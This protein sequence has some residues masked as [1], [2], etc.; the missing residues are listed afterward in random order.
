MNGTNISRIEDGTASPVWLRRC[1]VLIWLASVLFSARP[2]AQTPQLPDEEWLFSDWEQKTTEVNEGT[3]RVLSTPPSTALHR[4]LNRIRI[5]P[6]SLRHG[7]VELSQCHENLDAVPDLQIQFRRG[8][9]R[10]LRITETHGIEHARVQEDSV[11]LRNISRRSRLC[12]SLQTLAL[13]RRDTGY[14][15]VTGPYMRRFLDGYYP[16]FVSVQVDY[17]AELL[18]FRDAEPV[19]FERLAQGGVALQLWFEGELTLR[20]RFTPVAQ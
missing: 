17:P 19:A 2:Q 7:W 16:M 4:H 9:T 8:K 10:Y 15:L 6:G 13:H 18:Q 12:L 14:E 5:L 20:L 1:A 11:Q 3:L